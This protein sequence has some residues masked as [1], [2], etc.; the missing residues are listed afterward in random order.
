VSR[1]RK[2]PGTSKQ[3]G[4]STTRHLEAVRDEDAVEDGPIPTAP[5]GLSTK[6][7]ERWNAFWRS[8]LAAYV[9]PGADA[10]RLERWIMDVDEYDRV[11]E[12]YDKA[13]TVDGSKGQPRLNPLA[14]RLNTL[15]KQIREA[16]NQFGMTPAARLKLGISFGKGGPVTAEDLNR[17]VEGNDGSGEDDIEEEVAQGF[18]EA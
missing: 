10:H 16:E 4:T 17:M 6:S 2:P 11:R 18:V 14:S 15:E 1:R 12:A 8:K 7:T 9:D 13:P 5:A 3:Q